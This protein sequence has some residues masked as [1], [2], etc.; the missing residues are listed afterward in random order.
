MRRTL[1][2][3]AWTSA[4]PGEAVEALRRVLSR[5]PPAPHS[6]GS[7]VDP[8]R[9]ALL[10]V[11]SGRDP[12]HAAPYALLR[13]LYER[14]AEED[15]HAI[16]EI[17]RSSRHALDSGEEEESGLPRAIA[18]LPLG[19]RRSLARGDDPHLLEKLARD[20]DPIVLRHLLQN[21]RTREDDVLRIASRRPAR[22]AALVEIHRSPR[23]SRRTRV[24][25]AL[26][27]NP[28]CP[29][30][31]ALRALGGI[32]LTELREV[33]RDGTLSPELRA[34]AQRECE[35]RGSDDA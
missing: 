35:R 6:G 34:W 5:P 24:R 16:L 18:E 14:A 19:V 27:R 21:P 7:A 33:A 25:V 22:E 15:D 9:D 4:D 32:P 2:L 26:A 1:V 30:D 10:D 29:S 17:L 23:W 11:L 13:D 3:E 28:G 8:L 20:P 12:R 31:I